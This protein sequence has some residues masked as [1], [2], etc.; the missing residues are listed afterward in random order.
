MLTF[1]ASVKAG[2]T[3]A[4]APKYS[5]SAYDILSTQYQIIHSPDVLIFEGL[6]ILQ[7]EGKVVASDYIDL[8]LYLDAEE[9]DLEEW[10]LKRF[11]RLQKTAFQ[12][13]TSYFHQCR[14]LSLEEA[15]L[16]ATSIWRETNLPNLRSNILTL[17]S[18]A[19]V[20]L[21]KCSDHSLSEIWLRNC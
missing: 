7:A 2:S 4:V 12:D 6:N 16:V 1:L 9:A 8:L 3:T 21:R 17:R 10:Y 11:L 20:V 5:H 14:N 13:S 19:D 18:H 15:K